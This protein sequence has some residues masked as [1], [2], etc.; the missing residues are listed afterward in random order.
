MD[1]VPIALAPP[2]GG[3]GQGAPG[4]APGGEGKG[5][6]GSMLVPLLLMF[7]IFYFLLIRP[8][9]KRTKEHQ[10]MVSELQKGDKV[11][12][13]GGVHGVVSSIKDTTIMVKVAENVK[14][15]V[16]RGSISRVEK[17]ASAD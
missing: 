5:G 9:Q 2:P 4:C 14:L 17:K 6:M 16:S 12:T 8:Q 13:A 3:E 1:Y 15:E 10:K 7:A 11:V